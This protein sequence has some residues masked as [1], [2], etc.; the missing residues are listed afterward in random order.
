MRETD[1]LA[2]FGG[3]IP[4]KQAVGI[5]G[6]VA[7]IAS[8]DNTRGIHTG[9]HV[10]RDT[11]GGVIL[12]ATDAY[13]LLSVTVPGVAGSTFDPF[14]L[15]GKELVA[16]AKNVG[17]GKHALMLS[18]NGSDYVHVFGHS[19][20]ESESYGSVPVYAGTFSNYRGL[21]D[22]AETNPVWPDSTETVRV[23]PELFSG[24]FDACATISGYS[25]RPKGAPMPSVDIVRMSASKVTVISGSAANGVTYRG[26]IMPLRK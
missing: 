19:G 12:T 8:K 15:H 16:T 14:T 18:A 23:N 13:R 20:H 1:T 25:D 7:S 11:D 9:V 6:A 3:P 10:E 22:S 24:L 26:L 2:V 17:K 5:I 21:F 4:V